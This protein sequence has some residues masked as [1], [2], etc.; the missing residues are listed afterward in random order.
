MTVEFERLPTGVIMNLSQFFPLKYYQSQSFA[1]RCTH[2]AIGDY[3][4]VH[5]LLREIFERLKELH[6]KTLC[7]ATEAVSLANLI[8]DPLSIEQM[9]ALVRSYARTISS[10]LP[11][12]RSQLLT[13]NCDI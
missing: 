9:L 5:L 7:P 10:R 13:L 1:E 12:V 2:E 8:A 3:V 4:A 6:R 11:E